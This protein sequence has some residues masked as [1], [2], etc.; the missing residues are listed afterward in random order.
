MD[1]D[2]FDQ[3]FFR[4]CIGLWEREKEIKPKNAVIFLKFFFKV[5]IYKF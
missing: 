4:N 3:A 1:F 5:V 2:A